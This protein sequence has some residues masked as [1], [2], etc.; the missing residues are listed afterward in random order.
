[1]LL[2][3]E[4]EMKWNPKNYKHYIEKGYTFTNWGDS[5]TVKI[6]D[7]FGYSSAMVIYKCDYCGE[8]ITVS[9]CNYKKNHNINEYVKKDCCK[10]CASKKRLEIIDV[11][12]RLGL[13]N[14]NNSG[15]W[16]KY[17]W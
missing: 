6:E 17:N 9:F 5:F 16:K 2:T 13:L 1:M 15:Y 11:Q 10:K 12:N 4:T 14:K 3:K 7:I 8:E